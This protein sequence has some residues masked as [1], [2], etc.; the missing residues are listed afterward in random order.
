MILHLTRK[1]KFTKPFIDL[2]KENFDVNKH[3]FLLVGGQ[4]KKEFELEDNSYIKTLHNKKEFLKY[5]IEFNKKMY[6]ADKIIIHGLSQPYNIVYLFFNP[7][8]LKKTYWVMW[9]NDLYSYLKP[10]I[11][12]KQKLLEV[13]I[14]QVIKKMAHFITYIKGDYELAQK[15]YGAKGEYHECFMYPSNLYKEYDIKPKE[16]DTINIQLG[17]SADPTNNH[18]DVLKQFAKYKD[19]NIQIFV[20]LSYG[21]EEYAKE[22]IAYGEELFR[23]KFIPLREFMPFEK[24]LE[25]LSEIDIAIF[26]HKRQQAMGNI[27][28][29]LGLGKKVYIRSDIT[30]WELFNDIDVQ[31]FDVDDIKIDLIGEQIKKEN[32]QKI[33]EYFSKEN[34]LNQLQNLFES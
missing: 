8:L 2:L 14:K 17:N 11:T 3:F 25:F 15:W 22:V 13:I 28:T 9:G 20:P 33:K 32:Q 21:N 16:H 26:T 7:W 27:I 10:R 5:F 31:V 34:Y 30:P 24:Y 19:E 4:N 23:E 29:L 1:E 18:I 12:F 6:K